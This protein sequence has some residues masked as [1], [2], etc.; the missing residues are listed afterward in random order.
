MHGR[1]AMFNVQRAITPQVSKSE[2]QFM[3]SHD[4]VHLCEVW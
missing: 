1:M 3:S 2:L 4:A